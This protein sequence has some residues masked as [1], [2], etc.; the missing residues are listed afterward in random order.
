MNLSSPS[1]IIYSFKGY[2][3]VEWGSYLSKGSLK[4]E[5]KIIEIRAISYVHDHSYIE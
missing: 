1:F 5:E 2:T 4:R 3:L